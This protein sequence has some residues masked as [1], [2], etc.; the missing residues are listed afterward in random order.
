V[1]TL[2]VCVALLVFS[3]V[4]LADDDL[5]KSRSEALLMEAKDALPLTPFYDPPQPLAAAA[6]GT[7]I[8]SAPF[9][10]YSLP[11]GA[12]ATRILYHSRALNGDDVAASGVVLIPA[13]A[14]P[15]EGWPVIAWAHGTSGV[16]RMCAPSLMKDV[17]YGEEGLMPMSGLALPANISTT[18]RFR[19]RTMSSIQFL[20]RMPRYRV[21]AG[22]GSQ[23]VILRAE[24]PSGALPNSKPV[25]MTRATSV[26]FPLPGI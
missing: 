9:A 18:T 4:V 22:N 5:P 16:A 8:R 20:R 6:P 11:K 26:R 25:A 13:G 7:L 19:R 21:S 15:P 10:G 23:S 3:A 12:T 2:V 1:S 17:E 24:S 14:P